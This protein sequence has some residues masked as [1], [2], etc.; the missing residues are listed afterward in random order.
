MWTA[1]SPFSSALEGGGG[2]GSDAAAGQAGEP[3]ADA[4]SELLLNR[5]ETR[6]VTSFLVRWRGRTSAAEELGS[7]PEKVAADSAEYDS[8]LR[9]VT[10]APRCPCPPRPLGQAPGWRFHQESTSGRAGTAGF[11]G[12][13]LVSAGASG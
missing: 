7:C 13:V 11:S 9:V 2:G 1:S 3:E 5:T 4:D 8:M 10:R 6:G 12:R